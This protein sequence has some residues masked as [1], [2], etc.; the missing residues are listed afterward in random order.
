MSCFSCHRGPVPLLRPPPSFYPP[1]YL[2]RP[3]RL[4]EQTRY[5]C[6]PR[7]SIRT[8]LRHSL[9]RVLTKGGCYGRKEGDRIWDWLSF[10][11]GQDI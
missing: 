8:L 9:R 1:T 2:L 3:Y 11:G 5:L 4:S 10:P 7:Y 6:S